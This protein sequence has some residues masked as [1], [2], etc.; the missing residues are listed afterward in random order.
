MGLFDNN[1]GTESPGIMGL[2]TDFDKNGTAVV[3]S[4]N[5]VTLMAIATYG[6]SHKWLFLEAAGIEPASCDAW[7]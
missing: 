3:V 5:S 2:L 4:N 6:M 7:K 1:Y